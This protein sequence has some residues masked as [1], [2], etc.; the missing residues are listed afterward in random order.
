MEEAASA[1]VNEPAL[2]KIVKEKN[3]KEIYSRLKSNLETLSLNFSLPHP[4]FE[5]VSFVLCCF[6]LRN[7]FFNC[8]GL[9]RA[10][11]GSCSSSSS[12]YN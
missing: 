5:A 3:K 8:G 6:C 1:R 12:V 7:Y 11:V 2:D 10:P 4:V 9:E